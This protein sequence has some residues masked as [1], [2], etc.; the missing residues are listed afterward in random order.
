[1]AT[2]TLEGNQINTNGDLPAVGSEAPDFSLA[3]ADLADV[4][5]G[6]YAGKRKL[7]NIVPSLD[8]GVCAAS[9]VKFNQAMG[10]KSNSVA[11]VISADLPFA[12]GRFCSAEGI[13]NVISLS[14]MRNRNFAKD[15][16]V[17]IT[18]GPLAGI[19]ARAV[20]VLDEENKVLYTQLVPEIV[21]EPDYDPALAHLN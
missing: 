21:Q 17:L 3:G 18:D 15:Y 14:M 6:N 16:G 1:M 10:D 13:D 19:C 7:L 12:Q 2:I 4:S 20:V 8:T 5:L 11:L 9:T